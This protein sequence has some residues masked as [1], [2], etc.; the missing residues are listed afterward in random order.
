MN[1]DSCRD[2]RAALSLAETVNICE[3]AL[4]VLSVAML[5]LCKNALLNIGQPIKD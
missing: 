2:Q 4:L 3:D 1:R 5:C